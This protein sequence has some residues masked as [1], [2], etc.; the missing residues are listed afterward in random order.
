MLSKRRV[1]CI[2]S[3]GNKCAWPKASFA[4]VPNY[5][6]TVAEARRVGILA[7]HWCGRGSSCPLIT[8]WRKRRSC[9]A[10]RSDG[11]GENGL[12]MVRRWRVSRTPSGSKLFG[13]NGFSSVTRANR[14]YSTYV[15][16]PHESIQGGI[17]EVARRRLGRLNFLQSV[18]L[19]ARND[20]IG[21]Q[22]RRPPLRYQTFC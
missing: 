17:H 11:Y 2:S 14:I 18:G 16:L 13:A 21:P 7:Q 10:K 4:C 22:R 9:A 3:L 8:S 6:D 20:G 15:K 5:A 1:I 19:P 12:M